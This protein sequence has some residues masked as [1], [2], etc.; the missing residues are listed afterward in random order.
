MHEAAR[1]APTPEPA[2]AVAH[3][4]EA[5]ATTAPRRN[6]N[7]DP[8]SPSSVTLVA[9]HTE[10][11]IRVPVNGAR[12]VECRRRRCLSRTP[13]RSR[14]GSSSPSQRTYPRIEL[15]ST[16]GYADS[17]LY[18]LGDFDSERVLAR[19]HEIQ[20]RKSWGVKSGSD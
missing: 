7:L 11:K 18:E 6:Q 5:M 3:A 13:S 10:H 19:R 12:A 16:N 2:A 14:A 8:S 1:V 4:A 20:S 9:R 15:R 17:D